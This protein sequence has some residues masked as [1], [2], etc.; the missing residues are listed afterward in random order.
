MVMVADGNDSDSEDETSI[1][2][3]LFT[4]ALILVDIP[5]PISDDIVRSITTGINASDNGSYILGTSTV[6]LTVTDNDLTSMTLAADRYDI[7]EGGSKALTITLGRVLVTGREEL[8]IPLSFAG[9]AIRGADYT[10]SGVQ[11]DGVR[12]QNLGDGNAMVIVTDPSTLTAT[13]A[14]MTSTD[15]MDKVTGGDV[16]ITL[17]TL[18]S[19]FG[20]NLDGGA[21]GIGTITFTIQELPLIVIISGGAAVTEGEPASSH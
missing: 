10:L 20:T 7:S 18:D 6:T 12:Y 4:S 15:I 1:V 21:K 9:A 17:G 2:S 13:I 8:A 16:S 3:I 14:L 19:S 11:A 5:V